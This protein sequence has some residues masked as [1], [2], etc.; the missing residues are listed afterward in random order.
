MSEISKYLNIAD[1]FLAGKET[2]VEMLKS[3]SDLSYKILNGFEITDKAIIQSK[4]DGSIIKNCK[5]TNANFSRC[6]LN[7]VRVENCVF[8]NVDFSAADIMSSI[9]SNC[10][11][12]HCNFDEAHISDC[13]F[14][15][16]HFKKS[17]MTNCSF[18]KSIIK[19]SVFSETDF[20]S[21]T[22]LLNK[23]YST[24]FSNMT[25]GNCTFEYHIM[26]DC[27]FDSV[28]LNTDC[29]A[30]LYGCTENQLKTVKLLFLGKEIPESYRIDKDFIE[31]LFQG[32]IEKHWYLGALLLKMNFRVTSIYDSLSLIIELLIQQNSYGFLLKAD[33]LRF[34]IN[35]LL[36]QDSNGE[37]PSLALDNFINRINNIID[38][39]LDKNK[40]VLSDLMN[41]ALKLKTEHDNSI[42]ELCSL[43]EENIE[44]YA[45]LFFHERP[46][47]DPEI[48][49][50]DL[51]S[52]SSSDIKIQ[53]YRKGSFI[54]IIVCGVYALCKLLAL[55]RDLTGNPVEVYKNGI[56][57]KEI[58]ASS[59]YRKQLKVSVLAEAVKESEEA[60]DKDVKINLTTSSF[61]M[62]TSQAQMFSYITSSTNYGGYGK[63]NF[64]RIDIKEID[65]LQQFRTTY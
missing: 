39:S 34:I 48:F 37:L 27:M 45:E 15:N 44:A 19:D 38:H 43:L 53:E 65:N 55:L 7:V 47:V 8:T 23:Y 49:F 46:E 20:E 3:N 11:F 35:I 9:F 51:N 17:T 40:L 16:S 32:F 10:R 30:Y 21:S 14:I 61:T 5:V 18:L 2:T 29:L 52:W 26:R 31:E 36:E 22:M 57:L 24:S 56:L 50:D 1:S 58:I 59:K 25:L 54:V 28:T 13:D 62:S 41:A 33:E 6:D 60:N 63:D 64:N 12:I 4:L 42:Y